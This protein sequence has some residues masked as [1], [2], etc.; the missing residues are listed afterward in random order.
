LKAST[1]KAALPHGLALERDL[2][3]RL[4]LL[5]SLNKAKDE[6]LDTFKRLAEVVI[7]M[8]SIDKILE[9]AYPAPHKPAKVELL[10]DS[11]ELFEGYQEIHDN[12]SDVNKQWMYYCN[13]A[14]ARR[15]ETKLRL[16]KLNDEFPK[17]ANTPW[18]V[19]NAV[20]EEEDFR[21]GPAGMYESAVFGD[22]AKTK[23][24]AMAAAMTYL[25]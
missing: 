5:G 17:I 24:R 6:T 20:V 10:S 18:S 21:D 8:P 23:V 9:A 12:L 4:S 13:L 16:E 14:N 15:D 2:N 3:W 25:K 1:I 22:R 19:Y 11:P 7:K